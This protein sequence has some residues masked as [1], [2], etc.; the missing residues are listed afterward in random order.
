MNSP[1]LLDDETG[2]L[3]IY[4][5]TPGQWDALTEAAVTALGITPERRRCLSVQLIPEVLRYRM[6]PYRKTRNQKRD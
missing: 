4:Y 2:C 6:Q 1:W 3:Y 5:Q